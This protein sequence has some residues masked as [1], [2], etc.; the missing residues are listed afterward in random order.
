MTDTS[1][2]VDGPDTARLAALYAPMPGTGKAFRYDVMGDRALTKPTLLS[3]SG[4]LVGSAR[5]YHR[6]TSCC[7]PRGSWTGCACSAAARCAS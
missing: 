6:F 2:W 1:F 5:D 3:G 7:W 4:G